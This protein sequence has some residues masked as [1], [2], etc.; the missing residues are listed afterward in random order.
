M[1]LLAA[2]TLLFEAGFLGC[3]WYIR[4]TVR[5]MLLLPHRKI[6]IRRVGLFRS[7]WAYH[8]LD[9]LIPPFSW[10]GH[11][12]TQQHMYF[13]DIASPAPER[14][15][16]FI[17]WKDSQAWKYKES[18]FSKRVL[19]DIFTNNVNNR[20]TAAAFPN[21]GEDAAAHS[22][23]QD[24]NTGQKHRGNHRGHKRHSHP[25]QSSGAVG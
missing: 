24:A 2:G 19:M 3:V 21:S 23:Q 16:Y 25:S 17:D 1:S 12:R 5:E 15:H 11:Q 6:A 7:T 4:S 10:S 14:T 9:G 20:A 13:V 18:G 22:S 8:H